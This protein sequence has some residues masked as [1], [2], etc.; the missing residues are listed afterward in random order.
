MEQT[1]R[2]H[3]RPPRTKGEWLAEALAV[4][5]ALAIVILPAVFYG[6][7]P[8]T[9][10]THFGFSGEPDGWG[11][12]NAILLLPGIWLAIY[13]LL[14]VIG[15]FPWI[16]NLPVEITEKNALYE[17]SLA[18]RML[19][20]MKT[21][22]GVSFA[23]LEYTMIRAAQVGKM[24]LGA[25]YVPVFILVLFGTIIYFIIRMTNPPAE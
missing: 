7:L 5:A 3:I 14:T 4:A 11:S 19:V 23:Y 12:K 21:E 6:R 9:V 2:P 16:Y 25:W 17:Y 8:A 18:R 24:G 20:F 13:V 1:Q 22:M 10:P 15:R